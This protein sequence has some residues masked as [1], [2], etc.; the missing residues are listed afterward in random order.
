M[1]YLAGI[2]L[3]AAGAALAWLFAARADD[4]L[5]SRARGSTPAV[6]GAKMRPPGITIYRFPN[7]MVMAF[8]RAGQQVPEY[9]GRHRDVVEKIRRDFPAVEIKDADWR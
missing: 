1:I 9:Q 6:G 2:G 8:D 5:A 4:W 3:F 7:G